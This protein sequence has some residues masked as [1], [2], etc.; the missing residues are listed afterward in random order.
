LLIRLCCP[1]IFQPCSLLWT[2]PLPYIFSGS[3]TGPWL[4]TSPGAGHSSVIVRDNRLI[5]EHGRESMTAKRA[6][7][8]TQLIGAQDA[9][10]DFSVYRKLDGHAHR[11]PVPSVACVDFSFPSTP[12]FSLPTTICSQTN[13][14]AYMWPAISNVLLKL[15]ETVQG[16]DA[17]TQIANR[18]L[19]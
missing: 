11:H 12:T 10:A 6:T 13:H 14:K 5:V 8:N 3:D 2:D 18:H 19:E 7:L 9:A 17:V 15:K 1:R 16:R 4:Y